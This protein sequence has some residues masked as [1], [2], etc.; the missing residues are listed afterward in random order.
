MDN[1]TATCAALV[2]GTLWGQCGT[3]NLIAAQCAYLKSRRFAVAVLFSGDLA[4][5]PMRRRLSAMSFDADLICRTHSDKVS[6]FGR[7]RRW[8]SSA[9][10]Q[11]LGHGR[12]SCLA[13]MARAMAKRRLPQKLKNFLLVHD[14][15][16][17]VTNHC[18]QMEVAEKVCAFLQENGRRKP[19]SILE[20]HDVQA[21]VYARSGVVNRFSQ[22]ADPLELLIRD[23]LILSS[24]ADHVLHVTEQDFAYFGQHLTNKQ[25]LTLATIT[26]VTE[27]RFRS[28]NGREYREVFDFLYVASANFGNEFSTRWFF[29][30]VCPL[31][32]NGYSIGVVG[33]ICTR[34]ERKYP[35][36]FLKYKH[37]FVG[38]VDDVVQYYNRSRVIILPTKFGTGT[39]VKTIEALASGKPIVP[40][41]LALRSIP[42]QAL[43]T[44]RIRSYNSAEEFAHGMIDTLMHCGEKRHQYR[45]LYEK[46]FSN[47]AYFSRYDKVLLQ[48]SG[49]PAPE[50][51]IL[52]ER[53]MTFSSRRRRTAWS[54]AH[55]ARRVWR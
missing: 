1:K 12:D 23:E 20:T 31:L 13:I 52:E 42:Q 14:C 54:S 28:A 43:E 48:A 7:I 19:C 29:E 5:Q 44:A 4:T 50:S 17:I 32:P 16:I 6:F 46:L 2:I 49:L 11:W 37:C 41:S 30:Q 27:Q 3:S 53:A 21:E 10:I 45:E 51:S 36:F 18:F 34:L 25:S 26:P 15:Q 8:R 55:G 40:T 47:E 33:S 22:R 24:K 39:S 38:E 9:Y 35:D